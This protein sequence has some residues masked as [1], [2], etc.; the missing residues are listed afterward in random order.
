MRGRSSVG[1]DQNWPVD[2]LHWAHNVHVGKSIK[3][4]SSATDC[5]QPVLSLNLGPAEGAVCTS[6]AKIVVARTDVTI[7]NR[8]K[9]TDNRDRLK[10]G[11]LVKLIG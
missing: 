5:S 8:D 2:Q 1:K 6:G 10:K 3:D 7:Q 9:L 4:S 11:Y